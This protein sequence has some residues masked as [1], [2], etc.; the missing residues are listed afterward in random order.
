MFSWAISNALGSISKPIVQLHSPPPQST[1][2]CL[3]W[4]Q[5]SFHEPMAMHATCGGSFWRW[6]GGSMRVACAVCVVG[7][8]PAAQNCRSNAEHATP[9]SKVSDAFAPDF[10]IHSVY[11]VEHVS[12][13]N[14]K[15]KMN[16]FIEQITTL[17]TYWIQKTEWGGIQGWNNSFTL[18]GHS[19]GTAQTGLLASW[20][21]PHLQEAPLA[22]SIS[23]VYV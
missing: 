19:W 9:T 6:R 20:S 7:F 16:K 1:F 13:S 14:E 3:K 23:Y 10:I 12:P 8:L 5:H 4:L 2:T 11:G 21:F 15:E 18:C 22:F 17:F